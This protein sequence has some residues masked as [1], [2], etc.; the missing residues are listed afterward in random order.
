VAERSVLM[1]GVGD[2]GGTRMACVGCGVG[3]MS[4]CT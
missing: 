4:T 3:V 1:E 2:G